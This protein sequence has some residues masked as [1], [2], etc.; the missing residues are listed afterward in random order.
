MA[1][2]F[3]TIA[4]LIGLYT[5]CNVK[6]RFQFQFLI[7]IASINPSEKKLT[8]IIIN[9]VLKWIFWVWCSNEKFFKESYFVSKIKY[10]PSIKGPP[11]P[12]WTP[13]SYMTLSQ[14]CKA[15][16]T[17]SLTQTHRVHADNPFITCPALRNLGNWKACWW[18]DGTLVLRLCLNLLSWGFPNYPLNW[19]SHTILK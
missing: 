19:H 14:F 9:T 13:K 15:P 4:L 7:N 10:T 3:N 12:T 11:T 8:Q 6:S 18:T 16:R 1:F 2:P 17:V 5:H